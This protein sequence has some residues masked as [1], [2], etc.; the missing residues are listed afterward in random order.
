MLK[1]EIDCDNLEKPV[2]AEEKVTIIEQKEY[3]VEEIVEKLKNYFVNN[4]IDKEIHD[5]TVMLKVSLV[6]AV[7]DY[8]RVI[9]INTNYN[10][11]AATA[12]TL[13]DLGAKRIYIA[14]GATVG[15]ASYAYSVANLKRWLNQVELKKT[16]Y[17][18]LDEVPYAKVK[19]KNS[20]L[21]EMVGKECYPFKDLTLTYP[22]CL[23][24]NKSLTDKNGNRIEDEKLRK[25]FGYID[26]FISMPKLK[27]NIF[28][29]ITLSV[30]NNMGLIP[31]ADRLR[32][33]SRI[34]HDMIAC[35]YTIRPPDLIITDAIVSGMGQ[36]PMEADPCRSECIICGKVG[37]AVDTVCSYLMDHDPLKI[38]HLKLL[39]NWGYGS[40]DLSQIEV[41]NKVVLEQKR[42]KI[43]PFEFPDRH[44]EKIPN[45][46]VYIGE[47]ACDSGCRG[48]LKA[49]LDAYLKNDKA[50]LLDNHTF[51]LGNVDI[52]K[53]ELEEIDK[54]SCIVYGDCA[55]KYKEY[56]AFYHGCPPDYLVA[57]AL[58][59]FQG[60]MGINPW[61]TYIKPL[62]YVWS[63]LRH[64]GALVFG[65]RLWRKV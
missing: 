46:K 19:F 16:K 39:K 41:I 12:K 62:H 45:L 42:D 56:G 30:K 9:M 26:Y 60:H 29:N 37:T 50:E 5:K 43:L 20:P 14:D 25:K 27:A 38:R 18:F 24:S 32:Y 23:I 28:A 15:P 4:H 2:I 51:I 6:F 11:I 35:L 55:E 52:P 7:G 8:N 57:M 47:D 17:L 49:I 10:L 21:D 44:I 33:H 13:E 65:F 36:G 31:R 63:W 54:R 59:M 1:Y 34:L 64:I 40:L 48:M 22:A 3:N 53:E 61:I 58:M